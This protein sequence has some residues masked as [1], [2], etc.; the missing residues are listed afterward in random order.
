MKEIS[1]NIIIAPVLWLYEVRCG[2]FHL[3]H[4]DSTQKALE[5]GALW[6][7]EFWIRD[8]QSVLFYLYLYFLMCKMKL[9][10]ICIL[11]FWGLKG[12]LLRGP[13]WEQILG[14][15]ICGVDKGHVSKCGQ[16]RPSGPSTPYA[17]LPSDLATPSER[18]GFCHTTV[19]VNTVWLKGAES[20]EAWTLQVFPLTSSPSKHCLEHKQVL[21][22]WG[23]PSAIGRLHVASALGWGK[24]Q[25]GPH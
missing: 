10:S 23:S 3:Y 4:E 7:S 19:L 16:V 17:L 8:V 22:L 25:W 5:F 9:T 13:C 15:R 12:L 2:N 21:L 14:L 24:R 11:E 6:I 18:I 1:H 20:F